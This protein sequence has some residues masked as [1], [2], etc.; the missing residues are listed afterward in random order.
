M[1]GIG[2]EPERLSATERTAWL[3]VY[4]A[5]DRSSVME[6]GLR[7]AL[8]PGA[9]VVAN[10]AVDWPFFNRSL[11]FGLDHADPAAAVP[12]VVSWLNAHGAR[13]WQLQLPPW[14]ASD[15]VRSAVA[16]SGLIPAGF[17]PARL[18]RPAVPVSGG[19]DVS[20]LRILSVGAGENESFGRIAD[21]G[22]GW[23]MSAFRWIGALVARPRWHGYLAMLDGRPAGCAAMF[24]DDGLAWLTFAGTLPDSRRRGVQRALLR[25]RLA[26]G[27]ALG[28]RGF[29]AAAM[30]PA[31]GTDHTSF[32]NLLATG[33][34]LSYVDEAHAPS[35]PGS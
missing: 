34:R 1:S 10:H 5:A 9:G 31:P 21:G 29:V 25:R 22:I 13:S 17:G 35:P 32:D 7:S 16:A 2:I 24:V 8:L 6:F 30:T 28:V 12:A 18:F 33:F 27:L 19:N 15:A 4:A 3:D 23:P 11:G 26:D 20:P 14:L